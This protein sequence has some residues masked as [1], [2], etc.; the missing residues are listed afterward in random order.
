MSQELRCPE[1]GSQNIRKFGFQQNRSGKIPKY[2]CKDCARIFMKEYTELG[3]AIV[4]GRK[5]P[6]V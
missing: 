6:L 5:R 3:K 1:C 2:R 4:E